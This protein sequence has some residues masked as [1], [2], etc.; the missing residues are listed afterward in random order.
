VSAT[1]VGDLTSFK[2][3]SVTG[4]NPITI[5]LDGDT[6]SLDL[7]PET[8]VNPAVLAVGDRVRVELTMRKVVIHGK[9]YA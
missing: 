3:A 9:R 2:W 6:T 8:L 4:V 5:R 1:T 7:I